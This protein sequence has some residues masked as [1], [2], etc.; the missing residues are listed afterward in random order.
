M[1]LSANFARVA[2]AAARH[3]RRSA[4]P[5]LSSRRCMGT[6]DDREKGEETVFFRKEEKALLEKL[7][8]KMAVK[9]AGERGELME[10]LG[11]NKLP[12]DVVEKILDWK[13]RAQTRLA[14]LATS[15]A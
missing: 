14:L 13:V 4:L 15:F 7:L 12:D 5:A 8:A 3:S 11:P 1:A 10:I 2:C 6:F 9:K